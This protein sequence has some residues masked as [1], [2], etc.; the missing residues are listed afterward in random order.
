MANQFKSCIFANSKTKSFM[1][2]IDNID[3]EIM[4]TLMEDAHTPYMEIARKLIV[5][6]GTIYVRL[7]KLEGMGVV[8]GTTLIVDPAKLGYDLTAFL[9]VYLNWW[10]SI[11]P[12]AFTAFL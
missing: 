3:I 12:P 7:K 10:K 9:G 5:S 11:I 4:S 1:E 2:G 6:S 8:K